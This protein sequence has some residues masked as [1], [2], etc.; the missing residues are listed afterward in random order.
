MSD[1]EKTAWVE[2]VLGVKSGGESEEPELDVEGETAELKAMG[3][4]VSD[5][6]LSAVE[7]FEAATEEANGQISQLQAALRETDDIDLHDIADSG[8]NA[9]TENTRVPLMAAIRDAGAGGPVQLK[10]AAPKILQTVEAFRAQLAS[11][12]VQACDNNPFGVQ[13]SFGAT[14]SDALDQLAHAAKLAA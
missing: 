14:F 1:V 8:L 2:R 3:L 9:L 12:Q 6:W 7:A 5:I 4:E 11:P 10:K 13:V